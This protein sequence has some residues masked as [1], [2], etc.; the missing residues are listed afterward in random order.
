VA[1]TLEQ[2]ESL[3]VLSLEGAIDIASA[4]ELKELL[5]KA[6]ETPAEVRISLEGATYL[7]V[8]AVQLLWSAERKA[9]GSGV[10]FA[11]DGATPAVLSALGEAGLQQFLVLVSV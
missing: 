8:T 2:S 4:V 3:N 6:L 5:L 1:I 10:G 7:D 11:L 9:T